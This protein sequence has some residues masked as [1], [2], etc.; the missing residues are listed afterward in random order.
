MFPLHDVPFRAMAVSFCTTYNRLLA[1]LDENVV[2]ELEAIFSD[3]AK[4]ALRI[5]KAKKDVRVYGL[6]LFAGDP[7]RS[8]F[9]S[10]SPE[11][12]PDPAVQLAVRDSRLDGRPICMAV[13]PLICAYF[14]P[15]KGKAVEQ[16]VWSRATVWISNKD[17]AP[18]QYAEQ[19]M[20]WHH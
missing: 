7:K 12:R 16:V 4:L 20:D 15:G 1:S 11:T 6:E 10:S 14:R 2:D 8:N 18:P 19:G 9:K 13:T 17:R 3:C 5:W